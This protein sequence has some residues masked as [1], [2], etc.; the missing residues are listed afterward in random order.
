MIGA[1]IIIF[2]ALFTLVAAVGLYKMPDIYTKMHSVSKAGAFGGSI[3][4]IFS[5]LY[6]GSSAALVVVAN[7]IFFY[8]TA[9]VAAQMIAKA[10]MNRNTEQWKGSQ[11]EAD[12]AAE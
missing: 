4:L 2:G 1:F 8:F 7:I 10:A 12:K 3:L 6:F 5:L 9:P 11:K